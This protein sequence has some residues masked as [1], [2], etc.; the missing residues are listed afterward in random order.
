MAD[1]L[2]QCPGC[3]YD[4]R[5]KAS[6]SEFC[7]ECGAYLS[8]LHPGVESFTPGLVLRRTLQADEKGIIVRN[9]CL[10]PGVVERHLKA[11]ASRAEL[12][13]GLGV[14]AILVS[15]VIFIILG[16][17]LNELGMLP[18]LLGDYSF[19]CLLLL[20]AGH[21]AAYRLIVRGWMMDRAIKSRVRHLLRRDG[22]D[23][24][25]HCG[26]QFAEPAGVNASAPAACPYCHRS[27]VP[28][29]VKPAAVTAPKRTT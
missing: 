20:A 10:P 22:Y 23:L 11:A 27:H 7:P 19:V 14:G 15:L 13:F 4:L 29:S 26:W 2:H 24:C 21:Y 18:G 17:A 28:F 8:R 12:W 1:D 25:A 3:L 6:D 16:I 5:G 9:A